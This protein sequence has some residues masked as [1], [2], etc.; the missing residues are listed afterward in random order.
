VI[1]IDGHDLRAVRQA[2][3]RAN[4]ALVSQ[5]PVLFNESILE[6]IRLGRSAAS[7]AEVREAARLAGALES[8]RPSPKASRPRSASAAAVC[9]A[10][11]VSAS[12]SPARSSRTPRC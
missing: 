12:P 9:P 6:N 8:S 5:E 4:I 2:D 11:S 1:R 3:L 10:A 7:D